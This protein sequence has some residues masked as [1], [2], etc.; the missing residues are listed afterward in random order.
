MI[1]LVIAVIFFLLKQ[2]QHSPSDWQTDYLTIINIIIIGKY[3]F[4]KFSDMF[5]SVHSIVAMVDLLLMIV[6]DVY[7]DHK[8]I[9]NR[10]HCPRYVN[11]LL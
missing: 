9:D 3:V 5:S 1:S 7:I 4:F 11:L 10:L 8:S 6:T 2:Q